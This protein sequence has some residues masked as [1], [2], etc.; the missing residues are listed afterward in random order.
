MAERQLN[1]L[2]LATDNTTYFRCRSSGIMG[3]VS[4]HTDG[5][6]IRSQQPPDNLLTDGLD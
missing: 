6:G 5:G 1:L 2:Q 4:C 3:R